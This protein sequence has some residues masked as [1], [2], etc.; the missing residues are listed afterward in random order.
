MATAC[1]DVHGM[2]TR[3]QG[4][5]EN[6]LRQR[7]NLIS[8]KDKLWEACEYAVMNGGKR[9]RPLI[10]MLVA[11]A[12]G[13]QADVAQVA[14]SIEFFH[15]ASLV[16]DDLPCMDDDD[17]RRHKPSV[18]KVYGETVAL[19]VSYALIAAGYEGIALN[20]RLIKD[21]RLAFASTSDSLVALS[22]E[23]A[24]YNTGLLGATGGQFLDICPPD[25]TW[26]TLRTILH[27]K[28][29]TLFEIAFVFG[30]LFG[31]GKAEYLPSVKKCA[32]H[33]GMAFQISDDI[34]DVQQDA[35]NG[36]TVNVAAVFGVDTAEKMFHE[37]IQ[38]YQKLLKEL[39]LDTKELVGLGDWLLHQTI[40]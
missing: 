3:F 21:S 8:P 40:N 14:L 27:K 28:T 13:H 5:I 4:I 26:P 24:G 31:G 10:T 6:K 29:V 11:E 25:L 17:E 32:S 16:A 15:T 23:N 39:R 36:R 9:F 37:E 7:L 33:F 20:G 22:L 1:F 12:L 34:G 2:L 30:W 19:L 35:E 38:G 18:H